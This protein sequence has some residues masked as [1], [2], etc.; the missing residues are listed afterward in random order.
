MFHLCNK[1]FNWNPFKHKILLGWQI[2][3][4]MNKTFLILTMYLSS[5]ENFMLKCSNKK[6]YYINKTF[7][8]VYKKNKWWE[9][10]MISSRY[11]A[12]KPL[13]KFWHW[14][15]DILSGPIRKNP[16][17]IGQII[18][19]RWYYTVINFSGRPTHSTVIQNG[20]FQGTIQSKLSK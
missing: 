10:R 8:S 11:Y 14:S 7:L 13:I 2:F 3:C 4:Y 20:S 9:R 1:I 15:P 12:K 18:C 19:L 6:C 17:S 16:N 5:Q